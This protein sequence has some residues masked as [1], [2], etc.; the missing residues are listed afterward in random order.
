MNNENKQKRKI[1]KMVRENFLKVWMCI[2]VCP[3]DV[4]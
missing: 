1:D 2:K 3:S 4:L